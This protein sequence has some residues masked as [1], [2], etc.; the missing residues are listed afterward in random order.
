MIYIDD[1]DAHITL[2]RDEMGTLCADILIRFKTLI[3]STIEKASATL[4]GIDI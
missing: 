2:K 3:Q 1:G 4:P